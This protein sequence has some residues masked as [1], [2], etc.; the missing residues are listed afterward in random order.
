MLERFTNGNELIAFIDYDEP[1]IPASDSEVPLTFVMIVIQK[2]GLVLLHHN[3]NRLQWECA[4][5]S[6]ENGETAKEAAIREVLE[7]T[8]Q[9]VTNLQCRGIFK[10]KLAHNDAI[11]YGA[12][13][14]GT[15]DELREFTINNES[16][17]I[18]LWQPS[19]ALDDRMSELSKWMIN[20]LTKA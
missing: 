1:V 17:R 16:D 19:E 15:V 2:Y 14:S 18:T 8:C 13:F 12:L 5:G 10:L 4:A 20:Y 9:H 3:F 7:E 6:I 11:E